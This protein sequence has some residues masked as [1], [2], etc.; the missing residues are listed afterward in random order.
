[1]ATCVI[2][3]SATHAKR[4]AANPAANSV[5]NGARRE[6]HIGVCG[7]RRLRAPLHLLAMCGGDWKSMQSIGAVPHVVFLLRIGVLPECVIG[8]IAPILRTS[9]GMNDP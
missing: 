9:R 6:L 7:L 8:R 4:L 5:G 2:L 1:M 3:P